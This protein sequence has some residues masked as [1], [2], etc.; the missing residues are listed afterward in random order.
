MK[1]TITEEFDEAGRLTRRIMTEEPDQLPQYPWR[2]DPV[3][4]PVQQ[5]A[6]IS[7]PYQPVLISQTPIIDWGNTCV[8]TASVMVQ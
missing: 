5:P 2:F 1:R 7:P 3:I 4:V 8:N 6:P